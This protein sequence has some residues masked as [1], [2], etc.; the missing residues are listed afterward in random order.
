MAVIL[1]RRGKPRGSGLV[2]AKVP[3][4]VVRDAEKRVIGVCRTCH[5]AGRE[6]RFYEGEETAYVRHLKRCSDEHLED[7]QSTQARHQNPALFDPD[8]AGDVELERWMRLN[9]RAI[10]EGRLKP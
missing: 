3:I 4:V 9:A 1:D 8:Q 7:L 10:E 6:S 2:R 5:A